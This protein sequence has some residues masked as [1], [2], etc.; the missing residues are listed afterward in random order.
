MRENKIACIYIYFVYLYKISHMQRREAL[1]LL[2]LGATSLAM[3]LP[4]LKKLTDDLPASE[5][6]PAL[7]IGHGNPMNVLYDNSFTQ[8]LTKIGTT[9]AKPKAILV[10]SAHWLTR[11]T[12]VA[13]NSNPK[14]IYDYG[15]FPPEMYQIIYPAKGSP[16]SAKLVQEEVKKTIVA[17]DAAMGMDHGAWTILK[18][19]YPDAS[20]PVFE[21]SIDFYQSPRW[22]YEL[23]QELK[24]LRKKGILIIGS[25][26]IVHNLRRANFNDDAK[27][28]DWAVEFDEIIKSKIISRDH[29]AIIDY[30]SLGKSAAIA[31]PTNDHYLPLLYTLGLQEKEEEASFLFEGFQ[32]ANVSMRCVRIG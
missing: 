2:A 3:N 21:L 12:F 9:L 8:A 18:H 22:H 26:N 30:N 13:T 14:T 24:A 10:V 29:A 20:V 27:V 23:A 5:I 16:E 4:D 19:I 7:F 32:N 6:Q 15:G 28:D 1:Q 17:A 31:V 11:G 25:G